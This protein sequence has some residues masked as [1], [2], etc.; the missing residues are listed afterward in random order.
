VKY[1]LAG[2]VIE[3]EEATRV[4]DALRGLPWATY[5]GALEHEQICAG[6]SAVQVV[7]SSSLSEGGM[8][9]AILEAMSKGVPVLV[10]DIEESLRHYGW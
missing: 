1:I 4:A 7:I 8:P 10:S 6:L 3:P 9:N 2:P 5:L